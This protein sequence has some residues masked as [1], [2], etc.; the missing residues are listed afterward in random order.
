MKKL[1]IVIIALVILGCSSEQEDTKGAQKEIEGFVEGMRLYNATCAACHTAE[2]E[3]KIPVYPPLKGSDYL[4]E[5]QNTIACIIRYGIDEPLVVNG[6]EYKIKMTGFK[7]YSAQEISYIINYINNSWGNDFGTV[8][9]E[10]VIKNLK[11]CT[12]D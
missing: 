2:G 8:K 10:E 7:D 12:Q 9:T 3:P 5:N 4:E 1:L 11:N 6:K